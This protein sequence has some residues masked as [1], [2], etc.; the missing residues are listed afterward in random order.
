M[1]TVLRSITLPRAEVGALADVADTDALVEFALQ[2]RGRVVIFGLDAPGGGGRPSQHALADSR[3]VSANLD[4]D[5]RGEAA[6]RLISEAVASVAPGAVMVSLR[7]IGPIA[8]SALAR[9]YPLYVLDTRTQ[10]PVRLPGGNQRLFQD[11]LG[12]GWVSAS[13]G[14]ILSVLDD[15]G[16]QA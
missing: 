10:A 14:V 9:A 16:V 5:A 11:L 7:D 2:E 3:V 6:S 15:E 4:G 13:W 12:S 1:D 8:A